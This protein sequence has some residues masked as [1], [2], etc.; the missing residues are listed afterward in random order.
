MRPATPVA[1]LKSAWQASIE[2]IGPVAG[3]GI[4]LV[5]VQVVRQLVEHGGHEFVDAA[6][7]DRE[8]RDTNRQ[9]EGLAGR[10][11]AK[12]AVMKALRHG[13]GDVDP[14]EVEIVTTS[15]GAP[16]VELTGKARD[17]ARRERISGWKVSISHEGGWAAAI[18]VASLGLGIAAART[19]EAGGR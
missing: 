4:D 8:Q 16:A 1:A 5:E 9:P 12:E 10:W 3:V 17:I 13:I 2:S 15:V 7:T 18:A 19:P 11:A 6:W 14:C